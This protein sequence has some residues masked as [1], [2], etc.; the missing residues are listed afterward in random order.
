MK[1]DIS[2]LEQILENKSL[3]KEDKETIS[4]FLASMNDWPTNVGSIEEY[5]DELNYFIDKNL[6]KK[7]IVDFTRDINLSKFS[8]Q[9]ESLSQIIDVFKN[10]EEIITLDEIFKEL[11]SKIERI[12]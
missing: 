1:L 3:P 12:E 7:N 6:I 10:Q 9:A 11:K 4:V 8:W 5:I 2:N